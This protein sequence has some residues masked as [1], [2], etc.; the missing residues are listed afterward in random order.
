MTRRNGRAQWEYAC[1]ADTETAFFCAPSGVK[2]F[3]N[4]ADAK[5]R[6]NNAEWDAFEA[7][8][9][10]FV[11]TAPVGSMRPNPWGFH[12]VTGNVFEWCEDGLGDYRW[13]VRRGDGLREE[14]QKIERVIRG[15]SI[16]NRAT[17]GRSSMRTPAAKTTH[18]GHVGVRAMRLLQPLLV[19]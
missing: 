1:R 2:H 10:G 11:V 9:D 7:W 5:A 19:R 6:R 8:D 4:V 17:F 18:L 14:H 15:G 12:D 13:G 16:I 3:A